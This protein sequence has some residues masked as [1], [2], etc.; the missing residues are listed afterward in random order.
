L[1]ANYYSYLRALHL[2]NTLELDIYSSLKWLYSAYQIAV[3]P[4][5]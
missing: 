4:Q 3:K 5:P 2:I 1:Y